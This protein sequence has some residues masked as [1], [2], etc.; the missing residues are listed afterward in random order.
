MIIIIFLRG[1]RLLLSLF[2]S[3]SRMPGYLALTFPSV[4]PWKYSR[5]EINSIPSILKVGGSI[6]SSLTKSISK[7]PKNKNKKDHR[8]NSNFKINLKLIIN[9]TSPNR[10]PISHPYK[11]RPQTCNC[12]SK[13]SNPFAKHY[14]PAT[15]CPANQTPAT[16]CPK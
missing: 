8:N 13:A 14:P 6:K 5:K 7:K 1:I 9:Y 4:G 11:Q 3:R 10:R 16:N 15:N 2:I 12:H